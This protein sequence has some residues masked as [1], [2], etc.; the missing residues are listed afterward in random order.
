MAPVVIDAADLRNSP[1]TYLPKLCSKL[2]LCWDPKMMHW[3]AG[4]KSYD[5]IWATYWYPSVKTSTGF[6]KTIHQDKFSDIVLKF[7]AKAE[8]SYKE[9]LTYKI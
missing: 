2:N 9:L 4:L 6:K 7:A 3:E 8:D 5:G 1:E